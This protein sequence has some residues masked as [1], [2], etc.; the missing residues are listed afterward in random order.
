MRK[1]IV[2]STNLIVRV[3]YLDI[4]ITYEISTT[5]HYTPLRG[6]IVECR[7][8]LPLNRARVD[9][10]NAVLVVPRV[11]VRDLIPKKNFHLTYPDR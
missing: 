8:R 1:H 7:L 2:N 3:I 10:R 5:E 11:S 9:E 6:L 4:R